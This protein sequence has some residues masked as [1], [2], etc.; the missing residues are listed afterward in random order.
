M[1][2]VT[3][4]KWLIHGISRRKESL[5]LAYGEA[6]SQ[7]LLILVLSLPWILRQ[8]EVED[9]DRLEISALLLVGSSTYYNA[10]H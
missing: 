2:Y 4:S 3:W 7:M 8:N 9:C 1:K 10:D 5:P 6:E